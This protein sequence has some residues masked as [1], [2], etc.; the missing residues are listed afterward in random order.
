MLT[1]VLMYM[2]FFA[3]VLAVT[4]KVFDL[5]CLALEVRAVKKGSK[6]V[7]SIKQR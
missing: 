1:M 2:F 3:G 6:N 4:S 7:Q 5:T